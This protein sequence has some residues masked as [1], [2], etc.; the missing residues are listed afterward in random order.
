MSMWILTNINQRLFVF[1]FKY[2]TF[3]SMSNHVMLWTWC[4][5]IVWITALI[6][7]LKWGSIH[8]IFH[9]ILWKY[10][11]C[12]NDLSMKNLYL[13]LEQWI[14]HTT[15]KLHHIIYVYRVGLIETTRMSTR[16]RREWK[17]EPFGSLW[18]FNFNVLKV[19]HRYTEISL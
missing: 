3:Y 18:H 19:M 14:I 5:W 8:I 16:E 7:N 2:F 11:E 9:A 6:K 4:G 12:F 15:N 13:I 17:T 10:Y 1:C